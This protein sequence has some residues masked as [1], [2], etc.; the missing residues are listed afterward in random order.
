MRTNPN[1]LARVARE[2]PRLT[3][4]YFSFSGC[5]LFVDIVARAS[6]NRG[7]TTTSNT[8]D[9]TMATIY[10]ARKRLGKIL[11]RASRI[12]YSRPR[13]AATARRRILSACRAVDK[14]T[15]SQA[16]SVAWNAGLCDTVFAVP[17]GVI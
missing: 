5:R 4:C 15:T 11:D 6:I 14:I 8:T 13:Y 10:S 17:Y 12:V 2:A 7:M 1:Q 16:G 3:R 9:D